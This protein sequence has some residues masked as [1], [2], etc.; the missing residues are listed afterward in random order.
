[1]NCYGRL[2][3]PFQAKVAETKHQYHFVNER[4]IQ[5]LWLEQKYFKNLLTIR[6]EVVEVISP[7]IWNAEAGPDFLKAHIKIGGIEHHGDIEIHLDDD[8]WYQHHHY[9]DE[10]YNDVIL[11][12]SLWKPKKEKLLFTKHGNLLVLVHL[13]NFLT[14]PLAR[15]VQLLDLDLYPYKKF[16]GSGKCAR[17]LFN[18]L[19]KE[20]VE[21]LFKSAA[22]WRLQMKKSYFTTRLENPL[23]QFGAGIAMALGYKNNSEAFL[24]IFLLLKRNISLSEQSLL[25][26]GMGIFGFF[27]DPFLTKWSH[28]CY[29]QNLLEEYEKS[30]SA[31]L[32]LLK[33]I[34]NQ[35]RP[36]NHPIRRLIFL[37]KILQTNFLNILFEKL[38]DIWK[39]NWHS[40][41]E[42]KFSRK[43]FAEFQYSFPDFL[44]PYW[45]KHYLFEAKSRKDFIPLL[46]NDSKKG[47]LLNTFLPILHNLIIE[48]GNLAELHAF[49]I[50]FH[51]IPYAKNSKTIYLTHRF[52]GDSPKGEIMARADIEQGA[53]QI[54][55]DFCVHFEASC[56]GCPLVERVKE[57]I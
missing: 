38:L 16:V 48:N 41:K 39:K 11:H 28:S 42:E 20:K 36:L 15:I 40:I 44:D 45:N 19:S 24:E 53:F 1:M 10:R 33:L 34:L 23:D 51:S 17:T 13:E 47:M 18:V 2:L 27:S 50:F 54:H 4:H 12:V 7:G 29:Y 5:A 32:P 26:F 56:E 43:L 37:I 46:G 25:A 31:E 6:N 55:H 35:I 30:K 49:K 8:S 9:L 57:S 21:K 52:F 14:I 22:E 3:N